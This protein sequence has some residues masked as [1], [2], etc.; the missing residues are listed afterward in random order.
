M[1]LSTQ[2]KS[3][4][5]VSHHFNQMF[6]WPVVTSLQMMH[7]RTPIHQLGN[8]VD[9]Y[10]WKIDSP[11]CAVGAGLDYMPVR[12]PDPGPFFMNG[13]PLNKYVMYYKQLISHVLGLEQP[14]LLQEQEL[15]TQ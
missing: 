8:G 3:Q 1:N 12:G 5:Q 13:S 7:I 10:V 9:V 11:L 2:E 6:T 15:R 4:Y 14:H